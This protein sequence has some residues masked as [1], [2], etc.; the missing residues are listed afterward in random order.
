M[1]LLIALAAFSVTV[2]ALPMSHVKC[3]PKK[4]DF[5]RPEDSPYDAYSSCGMCLDLVEIVQIHEDCHRRHIAKKLDEKCDFY[6]HTEVLDQICH[7]FV[8]SV[9]EEVSKH[10]ER[11]P[12][13]L[14]NKLLDCQY[15]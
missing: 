13:K 5:V 14:C 4:L 12:A 7:I 6:A 3:I 8:E 1:K 15:D 2:T 11:E 10:R 9:Y